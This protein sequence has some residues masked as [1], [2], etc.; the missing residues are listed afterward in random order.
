[1]TIVYYVF[2]VMVLRGRNVMGELLATRRE[3]LTREVL[4]VLAEPVREAPRLE[5]SLADLVA[6]VPA[7][8]LEAWSPSASI[9]STS[10]AQ[11][12]GRRVKCGSTGRRSS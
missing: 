2:D 7:Q 10:P 8:G 12:P 9:A 4:P 6:A 3:L 11:A 5:A 1:V